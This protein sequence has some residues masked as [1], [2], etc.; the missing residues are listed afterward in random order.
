LA[1]FAHSAAENDPLVGHLKKLGREWPLSSVGMPAI[2]DTEVD[3]FA[4]D[5]CLL[6]LYVDRILSARDVSRL[7]DP[8][9][10]DGVREALGLHTDLSP[11]LAEALKQQEQ[12]GPT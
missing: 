6:R 12:P 2:K 5:P 3:A 7:A 11:A 9:V 1:R 10:R 8:R 4:D